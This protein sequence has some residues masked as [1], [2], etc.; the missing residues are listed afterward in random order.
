MDHAKDLIKQALWVLPTPLSRLAFKLGCH[1]GLFGSYFLIY[2]KLGRPPEVMDG[3]FQGMIF[4][5]LTRGSVPLPKVLGTYEK[6][7]HPLLERLTKEPCDVAI[8]VGSAEG[9]YAVGLAKKFGVSKVYCFDIDKLSKRL[10]ARIARLNEVEDRMVMRSFCRPSD[11]QEILAD[12]THPLVICD[13]EGGEFDLLDPEAAPE[14]AKARIIVEIHDFNGSR[15]IGDALK[16]RFAA[17]HHIEVIGIRPRTLSDLPTACRGILT[18]EESLAAL[19]EVRSDVPGW[20]YLS[21]ITAQS[22]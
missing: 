21:P 19:T 2:D 18:E 20:L 1:A 9:F 13:C 7:L 10:L 5:P 17:T 3:P 8:D 14:L 4:L 16:R 22:A 15:T 11:L 6:E 12:A